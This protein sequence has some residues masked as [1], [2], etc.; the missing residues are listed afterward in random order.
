[1]FKLFKSAK[2][3]RI[4]HAADMRRFEARSYLAEAIEQGAELYECEHGHAACAA[5]QDGPCVDEIL[6]T[7]PTL[8][9]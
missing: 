3:R 5:Y 9:K 4:M 1:M 7:Y 8:A 2:P 6:T